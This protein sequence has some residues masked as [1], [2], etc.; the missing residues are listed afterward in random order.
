[1]KLLIFIFT[2]LHPYHHTQLTH[3]KLR[4][5]W[6]WRH[7]FFFSHDAWVST[8][9]AYCGF[10][11]RLSMRVNI[12]TSCI[13]DVFVSAPSV[14]PDHY[15]HYHHHHRHRI[16]EIFRSRW[17]II[18]FSCAIH[19]EMHLAETERQMAINRR[20][21]QRNSA[22]LAAAAVRRTVTRSSWTWLTINL[23]RVVVATIWIRCVRHWRIQTH[24]TLLLVVIGSV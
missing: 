9:F 21:W 5:F 16:L 18:S 7:Y 8:E 12:N 6:I 1:M 24:G 23:R 4:P 14:P 22:R 2:N 19:F 13:P 10:A 15:H 20:R 11:M 3:R 17:L